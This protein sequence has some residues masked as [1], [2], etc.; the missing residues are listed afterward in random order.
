MFF[1]RKLLFEWLFILFVILFLNLQVLYAQEYIEGIRNCFSAEILG[2]YGFGTNTKLGNSGSTTLQPYRLGA[3]IRVQY[4]FKSNLSLGAILMMH[5][6]ESVSIN[7]PQNSVSANLKAKIQ[8]EGIEFGYWL[9]FNQIY[10]LQPRLGIGVGER[11]GNFFPESG[12]TPGPDEVTVI[13]VT[14]VRPYVSPSLSAVAEIGDFSFVGMEINYVFLSDYKDA[15]A[16]GVFLLIGIK[17]SNI[18]NHW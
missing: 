10:S 1:N 11:K 16:F 14:G 4:I 17:I 13:S 15:N 6:G 8:Y 12:D 2:G 7:L 5:E 9:R 3:G 18:I